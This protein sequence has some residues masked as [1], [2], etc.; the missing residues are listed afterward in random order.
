MANSIQ[1]APK[2]IS[3]LPKSN[4]H[5]GALLSQ[6]PSTSLHTSC[7]LS[8]LALAVSTTTTAACTGACDA[9]DMALDQSMQAPSKLGLLCLQRQTYLNDKWHVQVCSSA[10]QSVWCVLVGA[11]IEPVLQLACS[12]APCS[13]HYGELHSS[14]PHTGCMVKAACALQ[15]IHQQYSEL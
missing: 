3:E 15:V 13:L 14:V 11:K 4:H 1:C 8:S 7:G 10:L 2:K 6:A 12:I 9:A 5:N